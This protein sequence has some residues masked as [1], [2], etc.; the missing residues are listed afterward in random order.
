MSCFHPNNIVI[1]DI[2]KIIKSDVEYGGSNDLLVDGS[3]SPAA[4]IFNA[5]STNDILLSE[6]KFVFVCTNI[7]IDGESFGNRPGLDNGVKLEIRSN[8]T[9]SQMGLLTTNEDFFKL[10]S[11]KNCV[12]DRS[13]VY[14]A[15]VVD[16]YINNTI[17]LCAGSGDFVKVTIQDNLT[18][19]NYKYFTTTIFGIKK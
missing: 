10:Y 18:N 13:G 16:M 6:I 17:V 15:L 4:F 5:D 1:D 2:S 19:S 12:I 7:D 3:G 8:S 9:T 11:S 14:D